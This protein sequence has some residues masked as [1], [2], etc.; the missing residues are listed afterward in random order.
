MK[1]LRLQYAHLARPYKSLV[2]AST[3]GKM[4]MQDILQ[5]MCRPF[6]P[7][8]V[9][10]EQDVLSVNDNHSDAVSS[11]KI[12]NLESRVA[13]R[14]AKKNSGENLN[15]VEVKL[16]TL[17]GNSRCYLR[18]CEYNQLPRRPTGVHA[19]TGPSSTKHNGGVPRRSPSSSISFKGRQAANRALAQGDKC[20]PPNVGL[21][22]ASAA[23]HAGLPMSSEESGPFGRG[24]YRQFG[25]S[26]VAPAPRRL[27]GEV[28]HF[29]GG[30]VSGHGELQVWK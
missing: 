21:S 9:Y 23:P 14:G 3:R 2:L 16:K 25:L 4:A 8:G 28:W 13:H 29:C 12:D 10:G 30:A 18:N 24:G 6:G 27:A 7:L 20:V 19:N 22:P 17:Y 1:A 11:A 26:Q 15:W 5:Q